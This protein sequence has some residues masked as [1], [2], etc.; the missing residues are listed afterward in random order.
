M[1]DRK[2]ELLEVY[3]QPGEMFLSREP[4]I[5]RTLLGSC[6]GVAF[7]SKTLSIGALCHALLPRCPE[8]SFPERHPESGY[9]YVD[10]AIRDLARRFDQMGARRSEVKVKVFGGADVLL[11]DGEPPARATV[12]SL[13]CDAALEVLRDEGLEVVASSLRGKTGLNIHF[14]T[15]NGEVRLCRLIQTSGFAPLRGG[16]RGCTPELV[17][18]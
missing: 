18:E 13:N 5:I 10:F 6:I 11:G 4:T 7:W 2:A 8:D 1:E 3:L 15:G 12:G 9:R 16:T 17:K 14:N